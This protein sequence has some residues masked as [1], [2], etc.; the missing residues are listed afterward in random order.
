MQSI[1]EIMQEMQVAPEV[2]PAHNFSSAFKSRVQE[3]SCAELNEEDY[4][5]TA[6][7]WNAWPYT[8]AAQLH[9]VARERFHS[10]HQ[11]QDDVRV[12][13]A[14]ESAPEYARITARAV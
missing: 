3:Y 14:N 5:D 4:A 10:F 9:A 11:K 13:A 1:G 7:P 6:D 8:W 12:E 2:S